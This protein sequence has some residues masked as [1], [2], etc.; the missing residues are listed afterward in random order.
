MIRYALVDNDIKFHELFNELIL[1]KISS[2]SIDYYDDSEI[3]R[4]KI[5]NDE[6]AYDVIFMDIE[7]PKYD[8]ITLS[9][10]LFSKL[11]QSIIIFVTN[12]SDLI[13]N[14]FGLNVFRFINKVDIRENFKSLLEEIQNIMNMRETITIRCGVETISLVQNDIEYI[15]LSRRVVSIHT[16][17]SEFKVPYLTLDNMYSMLNNDKFCFVN[18]NTIVNMNHAKI[19]IS[20]KIF[21]SRGHQFEISRG[22]K[23]AVMNAFQKTNFRIIK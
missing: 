18:R 6:V 14:A 7:M 10:Q 2:Q 5:I 1:E 3:F 19:I 20:N 11:S 4:E 16:I 21:M 8:G 13:Y 15:E 17:F 12:R 22:K 23:Q 9:K